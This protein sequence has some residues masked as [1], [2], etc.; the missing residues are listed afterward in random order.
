[1]KLFFWLHIGVTG[2]YL[3]DLMEILLRGQFML[4]INNHTITL[5][6]NVT[7]V[8]GAVEIRVREYK[9]W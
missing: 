2:E 7:S 8:A 1:M 6:K 3:A 5:V 9:N 4:K